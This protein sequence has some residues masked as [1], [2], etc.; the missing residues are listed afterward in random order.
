MIPG[1]K[2]TLPR[3]HEGGH[4]N[5][6]V[7]TPP[8]GFNET[9]HKFWHPVNERLPTYR[10]ILTRE[11]ARER[12]MGELAGGIF[13]HLKVK[14]AEPLDVGEDLDVVG[15]WIAELKDLWESM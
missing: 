5:L 8:P 11:G 4:A 15:A 3:D 2:C 13:N 6:D 10:V 1:E 7:V 12:R 9:A 14:G